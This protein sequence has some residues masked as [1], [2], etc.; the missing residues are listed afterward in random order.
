MSDITYNQAVLEFAIAG[1]KALAEASAKSS[2]VRTPA[3]ESHF[4]CSW[5][6][7]ALKQRTFSKLVA[8]DLTLWIRQGRSMGA[9]AE[10]K[11]LLEKIKAQYSYISDKQAG[12]GQSLNAMLTELG[13]Q[14]WI[15]ITDQEVTKKL[16]LDSDGCNS[17]VIS[18]EQFS[19]RIDGDEII[20]PITLYVRADE[21][22]F[23]KI[24][25]RHN[26]LLSPG[27]KK[28]SLIKHH[29]AYQVWPKNLQPALTILQA[30]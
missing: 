13:S 11:M 6:V 8:D 9:G 4:L 3:A 5:M 28:S 23:A 10:L 17:L 26:L 24:A 2:S 14:E 21:T 1:L 15:V 12:L 30:L 19:Q 27:N 22:E 20:K 25:Y 18:D 7:S 16:K 29:K